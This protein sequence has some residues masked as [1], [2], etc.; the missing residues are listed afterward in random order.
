MIKLLVQSVPRLIGQVYDNVAADDEV[1]PT[2][3]G[4]GKEIMLPKFDFLF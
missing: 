1:E 4:V 3:K 2:F